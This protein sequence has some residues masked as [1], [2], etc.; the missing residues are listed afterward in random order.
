MKLSPLL[1]LSAAMALALPQ[2]R[3]FTPYFIYQHWCSR[4][5]IECYL[6]YAPI[7]SIIEAAADIIFSS[8]ELIYMM[9]RRV[10]YFAALRAANLEIPVPFAAAFRSLF[11]SH[12][13]RA[14]TA[15]LIIY[16]DICAKSKMPKLPP[17]LY[18]RWCCRCAYFFLMRDDC[19]IRWRENW[20]FDASLA[21]I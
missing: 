16:R 15:H 7:S 10:I 21:F 17:R 18:P 12:G 2:P 9:G 20:L 3:A 14:F 1:P 13:L 8:V 11:I 6:Q 4:H 5:A 19:F